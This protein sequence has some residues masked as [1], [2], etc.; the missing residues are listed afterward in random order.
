MILLGGSEFPQNLP[1]WSDDLE[2]PSWIVSESQLK[3]QAILVS[4]TNL[5]C[6]NSVTNKCYL[7]A[8]LKVKIRLDIK[9]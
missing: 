8:S 5:K 4:L 6:F 9:M 3:F 7:P 2:A 1:I